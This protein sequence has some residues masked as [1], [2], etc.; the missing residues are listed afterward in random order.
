MRR[1]SPQKLHHRPA[2]KW[3]PGEH[4]LDD[5]LA[6]GPVDLQGV[7]G[8]GRP[9]E[10]EIGSGKGTFLLARGKARP[11]LNFLGVEWAGSYAAYCADRFRR[12]GLDN[13]RMLHA[14]ATD[15]V[16]KCLP[17]ACLLRVHIYFPDPWPKRKHHR[18][19]SIQLPFVDQLWRVLVPGGQLLI[20]TDHQ[21]YFQHIG[22]VL[23]QA[24]RWC[25]TNFPTMHDAD[26]EIVGTNFE[27][28]YIAQ[29]RPFYQAARMKYV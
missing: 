9:V 17:D 13:V 18:R 4:L 7:F 14:D 10:L 23:A 1:E 3:Q 15:F 29:G 11:E 22:R 12:H 5:A 26:G 20:V 21:G 25:R 2:G 27:R 28:K 16:T 19:R 6:A 24:R 8:N